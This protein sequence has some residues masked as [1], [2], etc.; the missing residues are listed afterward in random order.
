MSA[1]LTWASG[2]TLQKTAPTFNGAAVSGDSPC[3]LTAWVRYTTNANFGWALGFYNV[4]ANGDSNLI[5]HDAG[6]AAIYAG[7]VKAGSFNTVQLIAGSAADTWYHVAMAWD[8]SNVKGY[9][10]GALIG[11]TVCTFTG[12]VAWEFFRA[13]S[14]DGP[15]QDV[16]CYGVALSLDEIIQLYVARKPKTRTGLI[17]HWPIFPGTPDRSYDYSGQGNHATENGPITDGLSPPVG[18]GTQSPMLRRIAGGGGG[19]GGGA[20]GLA[21][22]SQRQRVIVAGRRRVR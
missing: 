20:A 18:W 14:W 5:A 8:G 15:V 19:G 2:C 7:C 9:L 11:T 4:V 6:S 21:L 12:R 3:T 17:V 10:N 16:T 1:D 13:G 22:A